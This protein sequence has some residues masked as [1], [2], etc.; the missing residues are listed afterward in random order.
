MLFMLAG[1]ASP[2]DSGLHRALYKLLLRADKEQHY[3][4]RKQYNT[5]QCQICFLEVGHVYRL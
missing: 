2:F 1:T 4:E 5:R 3:R